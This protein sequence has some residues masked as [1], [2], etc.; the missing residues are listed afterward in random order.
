MSSPTT[1]HSTAG[2]RSAR[3]EPPS[4]TPSTTRPTATRSTTSVSP[5]GG[6]HE[7]RCRDRIG[8]R[9]PRDA[10]RRRGDGG[11]GGDGNATDGGNTTDGGNASDGGPSAPTSP[12]TTSGR[13]RSRSASPGRCSYR[14]STR[15]TRWPAKSRGSPTVFSTG[16]GL[17]PQHDQDSRQPQPKFDVKRR[18]S[19][20][21]S[22]ELARWNRKRVRP[23]A[24]R[25]HEEQRVARSPV[26]DD[27][28]RVEREVRSPADRDRE[29]VSMPHG[30]GDREGTSS[31]GGR[32]SGRCRRPRTHRAACRRC[33]GA[34]P[35]RPAIPPRAS[36][37]PGGV[38]GPASGS[39]AT[40]FRRRR[41][42]GSGTARQTIRVT[43][44]STFVARLGN[45][46]LRTRGTA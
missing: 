41:G 37:R 16:A 36:G 3:R 34:R 7:G 1:R 25:P 9:R 12:P 31:T 46:G 14:C 5:R 24:D 26:Y 2:T 15:P 10:R 17:R 38:D 27:V 18:A 20:V 45:R 28:E 32:P 8:R 11:D 43:V 29:P 13:S 35:R 40:S 42:G 21:E 4:S 6:R 19:D 33:P 22:H 39:P 44:A 23:R 30:D